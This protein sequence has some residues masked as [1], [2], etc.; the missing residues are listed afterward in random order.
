MINL[1]TLSTEVSALGTAAVSMPLRFVLRHQRFDPGAP[2]ATPVVLVHGFLGDPT[3]FL[4]LRSYLAAHGMRN[5]ASFAYSPRF[6]YQRLA[7]RLAQA[8]EAL[9][10]ATGVSKVDVVG[11]SLGGLVGRYL[12][13]MEH[14]HRVRRLVTLGAPYFASPLPLQELAIYAA[15]D[16]FVPPP[17]PVYGPHAA[18]V[19]RGG[20]MVVVPDCG[21][22]GLLYHPAVLRES[23]AFLGAPAELASARLIIGAAS[24][25]SVRATRRLRRTIRALQASHSLLQ[26]AAYRLTA[27]LLA[28]RAS[29]FVAA[30]ASLAARLVRLASRRHP[31][32][33]LEAART[34]RARRSGPAA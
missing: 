31:A 30:L 13:E 25:D 27:R 15:A 14:E 21:H 28:R 16:A 2:H 22:W 32:R 18:H 17:H 6:D 7:R 29:S 19:A 20:R 12:L 33:L 1:R 11:H 5:F 26:P 9:C 4:L 23:V 3:N 8:I 34:R 10:L 24:K